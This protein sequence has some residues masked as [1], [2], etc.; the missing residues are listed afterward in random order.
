MSSELE[1]MFAVYV[2]ML[3]PD[4]AARMV[5]EYRFAPPRRWRFDFAWPAATGGVAVELHG[6]LWSSGAHVRPIGVQRDLQKHNAAVVLG[7]RLLYFST[8]DLSNDPETC[9]DMVRQLL[10]RGN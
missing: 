4:L 2:G 10:S 1:G 5:A 8:D 9:I 3:A 6:G 7:W